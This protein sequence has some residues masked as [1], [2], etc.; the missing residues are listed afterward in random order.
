MKTVTKIHQ[1]ILLNIINIGLVVFWSVD[2]AF[3]TNYL[4]KRQSC[5]SPFGMSDFG[6][7]VVLY[8]GQFM[9]VIG[10]LFGYWSDRTR[11][12]I[13]K[14][15]PYMLGGAIITAGFYAAM[16][17]FNNLLIV[18]C[19]QVVVY[20]FLVLMSI[21]YF[22]LIPDVTPANKLSTCN[23]F[24]SLFGA[25][26]TIVGYAIIGGMLTDQCKYP[27][28]Y[29]F[30]PFWITSAVLIV[31]ALI[32]TFAIKEDTNYAAA[33]ATSSTQAGGFLPWSKG[34]FNDLKQ[35]KD[36]TL[37]MVMNFFMWMGLQ[38]FVKF[39]TRFMDADMG[40]ALDTASISL[41]ALPVVVMLLAVPVG[42]LGDKISRKGL[43]GFGF[44]L[45]GIAMFAGFIIIPQHKVASTRPPAIVAAEKAKQQKENTGSYNYAQCLNKHGD[46]CANGAG[47]I[48]EKLKE[49]KNDPLKT[50]AIILCFAAAGLC[51]VFLLMATIAPT[52]MPQDKIGEYMGLMSA[53]T[54]LGGGAGLLLSGGLSTIF[55]NGMHCRVIFIIGAVCFAVCVVMLTRIKIKNAWELAAEQK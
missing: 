21:P 13:G 36:L 18:V 33:E 48:G 34:L 37:F 12:K 3:M 22:S 26:G 29:R 55:V 42:I 27:T 25:V 41:G 30:L 5:F 6:A 1:M 51:I 54:G 11:T 10:L 9:V 16:P 15:K 43:L 35:Y 32:T 24:F 20:F 38:G 19:L 23:A 8:I 45:T 49:I 39:F 52:L 50:T 2:G 28:L 53:T 46:P 44:L 14:R 17:Y 40:V 31:T 47:G 7:S 4:T